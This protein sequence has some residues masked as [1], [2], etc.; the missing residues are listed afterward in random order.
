[1]TAKTDADAALAQWLIRLEQLHPNNIELGLERVS[2]VLAAM[3]IAAPAKT[4]VTVAG[5]NGKGS[6]IAALEWLLQKQGLQVGAYTSPHLCRFN[7]RIRLNGQDCDSQRLCDAL[8]AVEQA[9]AGIA[10][11]FFE[12]TTLAALQLFASQSLDVVLLEVG[13]G[14]RLDA[15]NC[16][17]PDL[18]II[19]SIALD[20][21]D[22]LGDTRDSIAREKA[23][24]LRAGIP[25]VV[26]DRDPPPTLSSTIDKLGVNAR[27][28]GKTFDIDRRPDGLL[29]TS[30]DQSFALATNRLPL[31]SI[32]AALSAFE[33]LGYALDADVLK[34]SHSMQLNGRNQLFEV[35]GVQVLLDVAH[36]PAAAR[37]LKG[38]L[39]TVKRRVAVFAALGDK[40]WQA[41]LAELSEDFDA[42]FLAELPQQTRAIAA[43]TLAD[44][45]GSKGQGMISVS[46]NPRQALARAMQVTSKDDAIVVFGSFH[47][48]GAVLETVQ[49][50]SENADG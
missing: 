43:A 18:A 20:H 34:E 33:Q 31:D 42:W 8:D 30:N 7:E 4:V 10:L 6:T 12:F 22:W 47:T 9:R 25:A 26:S 27:F 28:I 46:K 36:N 40:D 35:D 11:T 41:M 15:V 19:T 45:L 24:I 29:Y 37:L 14:G 3:S 49:K 2:A 1:M 16:I 21:Q 50:R 38:R 44:Y 17:D 39:P 5:T 23:G 48:V 32:A 13:L